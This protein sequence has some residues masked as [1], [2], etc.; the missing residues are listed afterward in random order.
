MTG[1][2]MTVRHG[3]HGVAIHKRDDPDG[4]G[5]TFEDT[6]GGPQLSIRLKPDA[7]IKVAFVF[8][9]SAY[10]ALDEW[11]LATLEAAINGIRREMHR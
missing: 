8:L 9:G 5:A 10:I 6:A 11:Q 7:K 3:D 2:R 4:M 1:I